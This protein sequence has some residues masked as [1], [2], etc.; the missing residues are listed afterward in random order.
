M[1]DRSI[2]P[3]P[4]G[5]IKFMQPKIEIASLSNSLKIYLCRKL[6]LPIIQLNVLIP[7]GSIFNP[8]KKEGLSQL[9]SRLLDE[10]AGNLTGFEI[11]DRL[12]LLGSILNINSNKEYT[13]ISLMCLKEKFVASLDIL[14]K[15]ILS[16]NFE[17]E[18]F[19]RQKL[20]LITQNIQLND[21]PSYVASNVFNQNIFKNTPYQF[22]SSGMNSSIETLS[23]KDVQ[24]FFT[25][26]YLPNG[27]FFILVGNF[28]TDETIKI[29]NNYF[30][31]WKYKDYQE[32]KSEVQNSESKI[33][34]V[35][36]PNAAQSELRIGHFSKGRNSDDFYSRTILNSILGG[37]FSSRINLNLR[38]DKGYTYGAH[39]NYNYN[40]IGSTFS[41]STSVKTE[42]SGDSIKEI[43]SELNLIKQTVFDSEIEFAKSF[44]IR[45]HPALFE[46][47]TQIAS[48]ITLLPIFN[49]PLN[50]FED[51]IEKIEHV[52]KEDVLIAARENIILNEL[53]VVIVGD[54]EKIRN[55]LNQINNYK[56]EY[57]IEAEEEK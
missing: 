25:Q 6:T 46:T 57:V 30:G 18:N 47:Y 48:N 2:K 44:L 19:A 12:E 28:K 26:R 22:P 15:L 45:R 17:D 41:I 10:G 9:T 20:K 34:I 35:D 36:K 23:N 11:S 53:L 24:K 33:L 29:I 1:L 16:P 52:T 14:A 50:Y 51:Y 40:S 3:V 39:S 31:D 13:N 7:S 49:L 32:I 43:L 42:N 38:E 21:D 8:G 4:T 37:Q 56:V 54:K 27:S 55:Q 5:K